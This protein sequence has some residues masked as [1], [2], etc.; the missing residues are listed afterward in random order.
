MTPVVAT[1]SPTVRTA[2]FC[3]VLKTIARMPRTMAGNTETGA[4]SAL[5]SAESALFLAS[6]ESSYVTVSR[7]WSMAA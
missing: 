6:D 4:C 1:V 3:L 7:S 2:T 5:E